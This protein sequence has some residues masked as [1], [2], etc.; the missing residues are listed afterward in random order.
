MPYGA[1]IVGMACQIMRIVGG[2]IYSDAGGL[3]KLGWL[4][5]EKGTEGRKAGRGEREGW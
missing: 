1:I 3:E 5:R 4:K 2:D